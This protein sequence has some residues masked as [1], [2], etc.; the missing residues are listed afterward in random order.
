MITLQ[1]GQTV[2]DDRVEDISGDRDSREEVSE[3]EGS[4]VEMVLLPH[5]QVQRG[6]VLSRHI[7]KG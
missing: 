5:Y 2:E 6:R 4:G 7:S 1:S 3:A